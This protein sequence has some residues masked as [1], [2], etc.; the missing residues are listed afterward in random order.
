MDENI[1]KIVFYIHILIPSTIKEFTFETFFPNY[2]GFVRL[3]Q[4]DFYIKE[5]FETIQY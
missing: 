4:L 5:N 3:K 2:F 1:V